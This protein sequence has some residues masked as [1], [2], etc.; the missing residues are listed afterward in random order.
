MIGWGWFYCEHGPG[1]LVSRYIIAWKLRTTMK[2]GDVTKTLTWRCTPQVLIRCM[3]ST[4][5]DCSPITG[6]LHLH[7]ARQ[8][9]GHAIWGRARHPTIRKPRARSS[10]GMQRSRTASCWRTIICLA[11]S[12]PTSTPSSITQPPP[13]SREPE[14]PTPATSTSDAAKPS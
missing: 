4:T 1:Q 8:M 5:R 6:R 3:S 13:L 12:K 2:D 11:T 10:A 7:R 9:A 14:Q